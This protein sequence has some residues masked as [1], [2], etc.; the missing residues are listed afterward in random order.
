MAVCIRIDNRLRLDLGRLPPG[1]EEELKQAF[2]F[3]NP[4]VAKLQGQAKRA[5][6]PKRYAL[7][8]RLRAMPSQV[9]LWEEHPDGTLSLPRGC[10]PELRDRLRNHGLRWAYEDARCQGHPAGPWHHRPDPKAVDGGEL[11]WYQQ[12]AIEVAVARQNCLL[13]APTGSGKTSTAIGLIA[14]LGRSSL[15]VVDTGELARQW[16]TRRGWRVY[17][18][19][20]RRGTWR[21]LAFGPNC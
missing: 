19:V 4:G 9:M 3:A 8:A 14:R 1:L 17:R 21:I 11:R 7:E 2:V 10:L 12:E 5:K 20:Q 18:N 15:V 6:G 13:R 16:V